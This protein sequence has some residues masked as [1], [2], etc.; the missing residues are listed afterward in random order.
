MW[1]ERPLFTRGRL[2]GVCTLLS[3]PGW[4]PVSVRRWRDASLRRDAR[5]ACWPA[6]SRASRSSRPRSKGRSRGFR[7]GA[8]GRADRQ[9]PLHA[10]SRPRHVRHRR[11]NDTLH[12]CHISRPGP[13]RRA[14]VQRR[15]VR[16]PGDG[17]IARPRTRTRGHPRRT[18]GH[19]RSD[20]DPDVEAA[21][22]DR[23]DE[24]FL[25]P[26]AIAE[27][28]WHLV[29]QDRSSWTLEADVRPHVEEF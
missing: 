2:E 22:P 21:S 9:P 1:D 27:P 6:R 13:R 23:P 5:S 12:W 4:A 16:L 10:G 8:S 20:Q 29:E 15:E 26:D 11:G 17:R 24:E 18:R 14:G 3:W 25:D 28:Y 7:A 19:R